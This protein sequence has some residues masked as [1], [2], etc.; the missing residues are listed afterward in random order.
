MAG[1]AER[2]DLR[3]Y[4]VFANIKANQFHSSSEALEAHTQYFLRTY[5]RD[6]DA[7]T[8]VRIELLLPQ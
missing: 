6:L 2:F 3:G 1:T 8:S 7:N 5:A 4:A